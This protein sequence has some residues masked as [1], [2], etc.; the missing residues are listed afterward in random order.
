MGV[1]YSVKDD[2]RD[3]LYPFIVEK[4]GVEDSYQVEELY[5]SA[6]L[7]RIS[8]VDFWRAVNIEPALEKEYLTRH[9]LTDGVIDYLSKAKLRGC[10]VW[11]LSNDVS[12]W[13]KQLRVRFGLNKYVTNFIIS[14]DFGIRK[15]DPAI[16]ALLIDELQKIPGEIT[17][18]DDNI[19]NLDS[20]A[21]LGI[22]T[23]LFNPESPNLT[24]NRHKIAMNFKELGLL[25]FT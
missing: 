4:R 15:P 5:R 24:S 13:S 20:A 19:N 8:A 22:G 7:G 11:C 14:G 12:E 6:S 16:F 17:F 2:V 18:I 23:I 10:D 21:N 9:R 3:L 1:I 25:L